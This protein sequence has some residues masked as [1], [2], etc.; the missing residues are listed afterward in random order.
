MKRQGVRVRCCG[1][2]VEQHKKDCAQ[3]GRRKGKKNGG[4]SFRPCIDI[5]NGKVKQIVGSTLKDDVVE[6]G[7]TRDRNSSAVT[8]FESSLSSS[9]YSSLYKKHN[10]KGGHV[11]ML[12]AWNESTRLA[13]IEALHSYP[14]GLQV[15]GGIND[16]N[17]REWIDHGASHVIVTSFA[18]DKSTGEID[19]N[20]LKS[21]VDRV[22]KDRIVL[23]LSCRF[24]LHSNNDNNSN[25]SG[26]NEVGLYYVVTDRWQKFSSLFLDAP[27][28]SQLSSYCDEFLVHGVDVEGL[29]LG[30]DTRLI[31]LLTRISSIPVTYAGGV[32]S[33][34]DMNLVRDAG[35]GRV[36]VTVGSALD[37]FGGK[38]PFEDVVRWH[39]VNSTNTDDCTDL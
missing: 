36:D 20:K 38:L 39:D 32:R 23:D 33:L 4:V 28:L 11:I 5:H 17:A 21:L 15:G 7:S 14:L 9:Y 24:K 19:W 3:E 31:S 30:I 12:D 18:F 35:E 6:G 25:N 37:I 22:G 2:Q 27:Q 34:E 16:L 13:A 1:G 10:L 8:N 26:M 29:Q